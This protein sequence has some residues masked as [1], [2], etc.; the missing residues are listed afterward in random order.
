LEDKLMKKV[1]ISFSLLVLTL[2]AT[3]VSS[4]ALGALSDW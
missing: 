1:R 3:L 2:V 4:G